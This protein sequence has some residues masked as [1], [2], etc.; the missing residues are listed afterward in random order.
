MGRHELAT[1]SWRRLD[2]ASPRRRL[3]GAWTDCPPEVAACAVRR[4]RAPHAP[5]AHTHTLSLF[6]SNTYTPATRAHSPRT[7]C[8]SCA[9]GAQTR[10][11]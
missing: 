1:A 4:N 5:R 10:P 6:L 7:H 8:R 2:S 9:G 11:P 3:A